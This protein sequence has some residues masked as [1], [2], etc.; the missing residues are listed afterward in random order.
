VDHKGDKMAK[1]KNHIHRICTDTELQSWR[2]TSWLHQNSS[3]RDFGYEVG[4]KGKHLTENIESIW[5]T[6]S[7]GMRLWTWALRLDKIGR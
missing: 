3:C 5:L 2:M 7:L 4:D 6:G 1:M